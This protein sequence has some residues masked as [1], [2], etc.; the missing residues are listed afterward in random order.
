MS[1]RLVGKTLG[2]YRLERIISS[3]GMGTVYAGRQ[4]HPK[5]TVA[6]KVMREGIA[7]R[8]ALRRFEFEAEILACLDHPNIARV[9]EAGTHR[10]DAQDAVSGCPYFVMEFIPEARPLTDYAWSN[11]LSIS[12]RL[13]LFLQVCEAVHHGQ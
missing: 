6:V 8:S 5:R 12:A 3:G 9:I 2:Q 4:E 7:S 1:D 13:K 11:E 10:G